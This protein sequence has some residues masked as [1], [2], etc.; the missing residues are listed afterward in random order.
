MVYQKKAKQLNSLLSFKTYLNRERKKVPKYF[1]YGRRKYQILHTR[2][3]TG[4]SA[5]NNDLY[6]KNITDSPFCTCGVV[7]NTFHFFFV[8]ERF[9]I[10]RRE[11]M[12]DLP[13]IP[14]ISLAKL[15]Y[16]DY[17]LNQ[18]SN[19]VIFSSVQTF[20]GKSTRF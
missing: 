6:L 7:E 3:R 4:C 18:A 8:S 19:I 16:R 20:I 5:L 10:I 12:N 17:S 14:N 11:L 15:L 9:S 13:F 2:L 1:Y